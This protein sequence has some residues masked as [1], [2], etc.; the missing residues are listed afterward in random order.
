[1]TDLGTLGGS[2]SYG[3]AINMSNHVAGY[4]MLNS[5]YNAT[6]AFLYNGGTL[7]DLGSLSPG[8]LGADYSVALGINNSDTVVGYSYL[9][10]GGS[11]FL[12][13]AAFITY[14]T[15]LQP[16]MVNLNDLIGRTAAT[17]YWLFSATAINDQGQIVASAY[18]GTEGVHAVL[19]DPI[20]R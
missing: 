3:T 7:V 4:S 5:S 9:Q 14:P 11:D 15:M 18:Y 10:Y 19:L 12:R 8:V 13:Q 2:S 20:V 16:V 6:H 17:M 1:M